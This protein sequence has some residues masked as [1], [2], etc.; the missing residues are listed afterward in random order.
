MPEGRGHGILGVSPAPVEILPSI[1][2]ADFCVLGRQIA[3]VEEAGADRLH[4]DVMDGRFVPNITI[5]PPVVEAVR[6]STRLHWT[7]T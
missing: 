4:V 3:E 5:G 6:R 1:L 2:S 7:C